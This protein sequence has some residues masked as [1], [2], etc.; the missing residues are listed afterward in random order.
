M[1][2]TDNDFENKVASFFGDEGVAK[3]YMS[4][5]KVE[6][7]IKMIWTA[8]VIQVGNENCLK[9]IFILTTI[10]FLE[11]YDGQLGARLREK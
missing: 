7:K 1:T 9:H 4:L 2:V 11:I 5:K 8:P 10:F 6:D 3:K